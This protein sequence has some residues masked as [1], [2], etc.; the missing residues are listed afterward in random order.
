M[1]KKIT[2]DDEALDYI[3]K[4]ADGGMRDAITLMDKCLSYNENLT[5]ANVTEAL[6]LTDYKVM[7]DLIH[8]ILKR[9]ETGV[10]NKINDTYYSGID[11][12]LFCKLFFEF[13]LDLTI[14]EITK[15]LSNTKIPLSWSSYLENWFS[16]ADF[17]PIRKAL[18]MMLE[19]NNEIKWEQNPKPLIIAKLIL[20][21]EEL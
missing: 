10:I 17:V 5:V 7:F 11:L 8:D 1:E 13:L 15:D 16:T 12:K 20:L 3:A 4:I 21:M 6:G 14:Y 2:Y 9:D 18:N 19:L